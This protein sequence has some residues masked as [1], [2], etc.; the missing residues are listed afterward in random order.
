MPEGDGAAGIQEMV[1]YLWMTG[2]GDEVIRFLARLS[3][4]AY[5]VFPRVHFNVVTGLNAALDHEL[6]RSTASHDVLK[7]FQLLPGLVERRPEPHT[8]NGFIH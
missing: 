4:Q 3:N 8:G 2:A 1:E 7:I 5:F 6:M